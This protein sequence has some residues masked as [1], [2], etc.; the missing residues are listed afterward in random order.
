MVAMRQIIN[1]QH[2]SRSQNI[3]NPERHVQ[4]PCIAR[5]Q[6]DPRQLIG[7]QPFRRCETVRLRRSQTTF[8]I[9][10]SHSDDAGRVYGWE[11]SVGVEHA[12]E[13]EAR[14]VEGFDGERG[15][16]GAKGV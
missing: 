8:R 4:Q 16:D 14:E 11:I 15:G 5:W 2:R 13:V 10:S 3:S 6:C 12:A 7:L 9:V 1:N